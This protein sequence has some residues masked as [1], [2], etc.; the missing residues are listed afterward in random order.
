VGQKAPNG[1]G[2][3]DMRGNVWEWVADWYAADYCGVSPGTDPAWPP[4]G[5]CRVLRGGGCF[6]PARGCRA[7]IC[8]CFSPVYRDA[9]I[10][11]RV[12]LDPE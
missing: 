3:H 12:A 11:F 10:G 4:S 1:W 9:I 5:S 2:L 6:G 7:A 8:A